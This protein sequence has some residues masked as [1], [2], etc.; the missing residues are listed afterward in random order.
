MQRRSPHVHRRSKQSGSRHHVHILPRHDHI[1]AEETVQ[2]Q[3][4]RYRSPD[5]K[6]ND[7]LVR[8]FQS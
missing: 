4:V 2:S 7:F 8:Y 1:S 6:S 3:E 5:G